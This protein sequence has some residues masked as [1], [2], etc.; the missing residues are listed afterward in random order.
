MHQIKYKPIGL[1]HSDYKEKEGVPIQGALAK[2]SKGTVEVYPEYQA[3]MKDLDGFSHIILIYH[4]HRS[5]GYSLLARPF[6]DDKHRGI[7]AIRAP[8]R[9]NPIGLSI[10]KLEKIVENIL[11]VSEVDIIDN[12]PLLDIKPYISKIDRRNNTRDG[13]IAEK[14]KTKHTPLSDGRFS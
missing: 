2:N 9:P 7:F 8:K 1:I 10:V 11:Y 6:L 3:G 13:W 4:F 14:L 5:K 12:T